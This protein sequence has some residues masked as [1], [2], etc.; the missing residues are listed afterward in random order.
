MG[1]DTKK[2]AGL[3]PSHH[4]RFPFPPE[5]KRP[6]LLTDEMSMPRTYGHGD[7]MHPTRTCASTDKLHVSEFLVLPGKHFDPPDIHVGDEVYYCAQGVGHMYNPETGETTPANTGD[8]ILIPAGTWHQ[9]W[10]FGEVPVK[11]VNWI[12]PMLWSEKSRGTC[13]SFDKAPK[14]YKGEEEE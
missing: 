5:G 9:V 13:I 8:F 1:E 3:V 12:A 10:N 4:G 2:P 11:M 6:A 7:G 14:Y